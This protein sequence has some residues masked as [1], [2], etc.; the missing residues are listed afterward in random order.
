MR[1]AGLTCAP[2][3][4]YLSN[5]LSLATTSPYIPTSSSFFRLIDARKA[6]LAVNAQR[7]MVN[8]DG[9]DVTQGYAH[10]PQIREA[11]YEREKAGQD[12]SF[13]DVLDHR[14]MRSHR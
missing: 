14:G 6:I 13:S 8:Q 2:H 7:K 11:L 5:S 12:C 10:S 9:T 3:A 1:F 4:L